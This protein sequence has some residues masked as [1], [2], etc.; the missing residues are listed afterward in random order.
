[1]L[2]IEAQLTIRHGEGFVAS[3]DGVEASMTYLE[4]R[5]LGRDWRDLL[6]D[7]LVQAWTDR[8]CNPANWKLAGPAMIGAH[9][10]APVVRR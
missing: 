6:L 10:G 3:Y 8:F 9:T 4:A 1:M 2:V 7:R 5:D